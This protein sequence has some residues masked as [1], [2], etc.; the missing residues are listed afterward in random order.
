MNTRQLPHSAGHT[1][2]RAPVALPGAD[3]VPRHSPPRAVGA[4]LARRSGGTRALLAACLVALVAAGALPGAGGAVRADDAAAVAPPPRSPDY[5]S[6][7]PD[8]ITL[9]RFSDSEPFKGMT[10]ST[11]RDMPMAVYGF[12]SPLAVRSN[13]AE[14]F[15]QLVLYPI[16]R[17]AADYNVTEKVVAPHPFSPMPGAPFGLRGMFGYLSKD[18]F[19]ANPVAVPMV[20]DMAEAVHQDGQREL[21]IALSGKIGDQEESGI[22]GLNIHPYGFT[23]ASF[24]SLYRVLRPAP[25]EAPVPRL[26]LTFAHPGNINDVDIVEWRDQNGKNHIICLAGGNDDYVGNHAVNRHRA[27]Y[28]Y[29]NSPF[30]RSSPSIFYVSFYPKGPVM[31]AEE[32][33]GDLDHQPAGVGI[34]PQGLSLAYFPRFDSAFGVRQD[35]VFYPFPAVDLSRFPGDMDYGYRRPPQPGDM[36]DPQFNN[37][38]RNEVFS[39]ELLPSGLIRVE[40]CRVE[41]RMPPHPIRWVPHPERRFGL[42]YRLTRAGVIE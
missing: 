18:G 42:A 10:N 40:T 24:L 7:T 8:G 37:R 14:F 39:V 29:F 19:R 17:L 12:N 4:A 16:G 3:R 27:Q 36:P 6:G 41:H 33:F 35:G 5:T 15:G 38:D 28:G 34:G 26:A 32:S 11:F 30:S 9:Y 31:F 13:N 1:P 25:G 20:M 21:L 23:R 2:G 22:V